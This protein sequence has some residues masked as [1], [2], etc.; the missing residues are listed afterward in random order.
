MSDSVAD[1]ET[2]DDDAGPVTIY[3]IQGPEESKVRVRALPG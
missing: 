2:G 1:L 3:D